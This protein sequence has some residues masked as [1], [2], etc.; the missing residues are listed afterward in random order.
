[1]SQYRYP[2]T[3]TS[4]LS[5]DLK[6]I[7][8]Y[9]DNLVAKSFGENGSTFTFALPNGALIGPFP[10]LIASK[11]IATHLWNALRSFS[12]LQSIPADAKEVA[13]LVTGA[14]FD[15]KFEQYAH[16][17]IAIKTAGLTEEQCSKIGKSQKPEGL[18]EAASVAYDASFY[19]ANE[20]GPLPQNLYDRAVGILGKEGLLQMTHYVGMYCYMCVLMNLAHAPVPSGDDA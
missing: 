14:R 3:P 4:A 12:S 11:E 20:R 7:G 15:A 1:M 18:S 13:I 6:P 10:V 16:R 8:E 17:H 2:P 9:A 5:D 19:L